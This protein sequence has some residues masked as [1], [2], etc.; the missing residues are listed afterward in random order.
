V[1]IKCPLLVLVQNFKQLL[2]ALLR[3]KNIVCM[4][5][6]GETGFKKARVQGKIEFLKMQAGW[7]F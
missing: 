4:L 7:L 6:P 3:E 1:N 2:R 5:R